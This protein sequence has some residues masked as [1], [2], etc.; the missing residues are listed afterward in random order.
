MKIYLLIPYYLV[1][2]IFT[3]MVVFVGGV[4]LF[5][6]IATFI[7]YTIFLLVSVQAGKDF[8]DFLNE[9]IVFFFNNNKQLFGWVSLAVSIPLFHS[10][11]KKESE[12]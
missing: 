3:T 4:I 2:T 5:A 6:L 1:G 12:K 9:T 8:Q 7:Y 11:N 10:V